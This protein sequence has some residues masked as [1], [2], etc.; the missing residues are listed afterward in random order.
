M[1]G[2]EAKW[3]DWRTKGHRRDEDRHVLLASHPLSAK[4]LETTNKSTTKVAYVKTISQ[5]AF[6]FSFLKCSHLFSRG[7][8]CPQVCACVQTHA[9]ARS[10]H[11][12]CLRLLPS[13]LYFEMGSLTEPGAY[14]FWFN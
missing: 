8:M 7:Y 3:S 10:Q 11:W 6:K 5:R 12:E 1:K 2:S 14:W 13:I 9:G 4:N